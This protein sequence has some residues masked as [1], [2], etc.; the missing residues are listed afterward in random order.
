[1]P[2]RK[3]GQKTK[4]RILEA[5]CELFA[6]KGFHS[7]TVGEISRK[8]ACNI[9]A[10]NYHFGSKAR[11]YTETWRYAHACGHE[12]YKSIQPALDLPEDQRLRAHILFLLNLLSN[13]NELKSL[14]LLHEREFLSP[15]GLVDDLWRELRDPLR[16]GFLEVIQSIMGEKG[17]EEDVKFCEVM[18]VNLC[19][20]ILKHNRRQNPEYFGDLEITPEFLETMA[21]TITC[22]ALAG[23]TAVREKKG[24]NEGC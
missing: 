1:M 20:S 21:D 23:I 13:E 9:A 10:I 4:D 19:R 15:T 22:F 16:V 8:A 17:I 12:L 18:I 6:L 7:A 5:A 24:E 3:D 11:L 2:P 14:H